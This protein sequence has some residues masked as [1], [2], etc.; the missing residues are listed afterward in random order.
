LLAFGADINAYGEDNFTAV[1]YACKSG[2]R[3]VA[4]LLAENGADL[5]LENVNGR[6]ALFYAKQRQFEQEL[7]VSACHTMYIILCVF[8]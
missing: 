7:L 4:V 5:D 8:N 6:S 1:A 3:D 2:H